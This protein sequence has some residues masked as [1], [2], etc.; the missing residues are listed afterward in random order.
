MNFHF[1]T[2]SGLISVSGSKASLGTILKANQKAL[3]MFEMKSLTGLNVSTLTPDFIAPVHKNFMESL[4]LTGSYKILYRQR[5]LIGKDSKDQLF[6]FETTIK[7]YF[8]N[9]ATQLVFLMHLRDESEQM[10]KIQF[11]LCSFFGIIQGIGGTMFKEYS[12]FFKST[13][14]ANGVFPMVIMFPFLKSFF[15]EK[16]SEN[17]LEEKDD[18]NS[19]KILSNCPK[20]TGDHYLTYLFLNEKWEVK[21]FPPLPQLRSNQSKKSGLSKSSFRSARL[22]LSK[23]NDTSSHMVYNEIVDYF[24]NVMELAESYYSNAEIYKIEF[25]IVDHKLENLDFLE[26]IVHRR[27]PTISDAKKIKEFIKSFYTTDKTVLEKNFTINSAG[28]FEVFQGRKQDNDDEQ[29]K[30]EI[31]DE[32]KSD[33]VNQ[34]QENIEENETAKKLE[35]DIGS[36][37]GTSQKSTTSQKKIFEYFLLDLDRKLPYSFLIARITLIVLIL[38][39]IA[40]ICTVN[41]LCLDQIKKFHSE[42]QQSIKLVE[43]KIGLENIAY[44]ASNCYLFQRAQCYEEVQKSGLRMSNFYDIIIDPPLDGLHSKELE[45][46][47]LQST[48]T[49]PLLEAMY[50]LVSYA[51]NTPKYKTNLYFLIKN[52]RNILAQYQ[53]LSGIGTIIAK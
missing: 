35:L 11:F 53:T 16:C 32:K 25:S 40:S 1:G 9:E 12:K 33:E 48:E 5:T 26:L 39:T 49:I 21:Q 18:H 6:H 19:Q 45:V 14:F 15:A 30:G 31:F 23:L 47:D 7:P 29:K 51:I 13:H 46:Y 27:E 42:F 3:R 37:I 41:F 44:T 17:F 4:Y 34:I 43:L 22:H 36:S 24:D 10:R 8:D 50:K 28:E 52:G 20:S 2:R 38:L